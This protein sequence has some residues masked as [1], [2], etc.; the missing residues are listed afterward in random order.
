MR[1]AVSA[2][3]A[4]F[5]LTCAAAEGATAAAAKPGTWAEVQPILAERCVECHGP[6]KAKEK[7]RLDSAAFTLKGSKHGP[8]LTP[9]QPAAGSLIKAITLPDGHDD[10]MPPKGARLTEAQ[11][12][13]IRRWIAAG[14]PQ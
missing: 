13:A 6:D 3:L 11:L 10:R 4:A 1:L 9:G 12:D 8:V 5:S 7:L 2:V 14:A